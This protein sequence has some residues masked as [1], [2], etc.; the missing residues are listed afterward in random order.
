MLRALSVTIQ[1][2][3]QLLRRHSELWFVAILAVALP[4][5]FLLLTNSILSVAGSAAAS[6]EKA[7]VGTIHDLLAVELQ[8]TPEYNRIAALIQAVTEGNSDITSLQVVRDDNGTLIRIAD[9]TGAS[10][11]TITTT[12]DLYRTA[13]TQPGESFIFEFR[14]NTGR[15]WHAYRAVLAGQ[16]TYYLSSVHSLQ[17]FDT[18][19]HNR[20]YDAYAAFGLV[21][22]FLLAFGYWTARQVDYRARYRRANESLHQQELFTSS[23]VHELRAPLTAIRG[24]G[25]MISESKDT[26][27]EVR[28]YGE[29]IRQSTIRLVA[30]IS[31]YLEVT[32]LRSGMH[33]VER[34]KVALAAVLE[35]V[36]RE[37]APSAHEKHLTLSLTDKATSV[38]LMSNEKF[39]TQIFTN[40]IS[41]AIKYTPQG[42]VEVMVEHDRYGVEVRIKDTGMGMNAED[43]ARLFAPFSRVGNEAAKAI[44]GS[45]LGMWITKLMVEE[46]GGT[47]GVE[48]IKGIGTHVVVRFKKAVL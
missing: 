39:L 43:Q 45:G 46:L 14:T 17:A 24:Y 22:L 42:H 12:S 6:A 28:T 13:L 40:L 44:T 47:I 8:I 19:M 1:D 32:R 36:I 5:L 2:G 21:I 33:S 25:S 20:L 11:D 18:R 15:E 38:T 35:S 3:W 41:N 30:L 9:T 16:S 26:P 4:A 29:Q 31:D 27:A 37:L 23:V 7:R 10:N 34:T 48:S